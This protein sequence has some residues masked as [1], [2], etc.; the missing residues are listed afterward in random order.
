M[1]SFC[2]KPLGKS[3]SDTFTIQGFRNWKRIG[4]KDCVF[5]S[6]MGKD[7]NSA[8]A[9]SALCWENRK[10]PEGH[11]DNVIETYSKTDC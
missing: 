11:V 5:V 7:T 10:K 3:S 2:K 4:G 9:Y 6:H 1:F 8:H